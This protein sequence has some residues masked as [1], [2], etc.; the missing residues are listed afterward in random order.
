[1][2]IKHS[3][4]HKAAIG[5]NVAGGGQV[6]VKPGHEANVDLLDPFDP[7]VVGLFAGE[8]LEGNLKAAQEAM[9]DNRT[10]A[11]RSVDAAKAAIAGSSE[12]TQRHQ[13]QPTLD[14]VVE[15]DGGRNASLA[16][17]ER[18]L[19]EREANVTARETAVQ[20]QGETAGDGL[21]WGA[22]S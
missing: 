19:A 2:L 4:K 5:L 22:R 8:H 9:S 21:G 13:R 11:Q 15:D 16:E 14:G 6:F 17:R 20:A 3:G 7:F 18:A 1:M 10:D 12:I